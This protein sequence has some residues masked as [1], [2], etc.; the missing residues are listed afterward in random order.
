MKRA[1]ILPASMLL[2]TAACNGSVTD[3]STGTGTGTSSSSGSTTSSGS[4][5][6]GSSSSS[7]G[8]SGQTVTL[9]MDSFPVPAGAEVYNCQNF[10][11]PFGGVDTDVAEF[12]SHMAAGSHHMLLFYKDGITENGA[13]EACSGLEF[14][15]TPYGSQELNDSLSFPPGVA[16]L[17]PGSTGLRIQSHYLNVTPNALTAQ[18]QVILHVAE[19]GTVQ[20]EAGV[21]FVINTD[22]SVPPL[23]TS[24]VSNSCTIPSDM[25]IVR[26]S[27]HMHMHGQD[28]VATSGSTTLY[29]T[30]AWSDP[31]P[32]IYAP[33]LVLQAGD[34]LDYSC[35]FLNTSPTATLTFGE[36]AL[37]NEMCIFIASYY[38]TTATQPTI[39]AN[40]C[41]PNQV[42]SM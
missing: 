9:T 32:S 18:V 7:S 38:P 41:V 26:T 14:A 1:L 39:D 33:P 23:T 16:A 28:F 17:L 35:T 29:Q 11:N 31:V 20:Y 19:P 27:S 24:V 15:A 21:L 34:P 6:S 25:N 30:T 37:T 2:A 42:N 40:N 36:S 8:G 5:G 12:E 22:I 10:V 4:T 3:Q 13:L